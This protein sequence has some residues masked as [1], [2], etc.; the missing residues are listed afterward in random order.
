MTKR[1]AALIISLCLALTA[2][3]A[4]AETAPVVYTIGTSGS[5][6]PFCYTDENG[7]LTGYDV[8]VLRAVDEKLD[9]V[10]FEFKAMDFDGLFLGLDAGSLDFISHQLGKNAEREAKYLYANEPLGFTSMNLAV[11]AADDSINGI[12]DAEGKTV[13]VTATGLPNTW[14]TNYNAETAEVPVTLKYYEGDW[15]QGMQQV[16]A[17]GGD[18]TVAPA[19]NIDT[20]IREMGLGVR[21]IPEALYTVNVYFIF[22]KGQEAL[23]DKID[24]ALVELR[25][26]GTLGEISVTFL[27][28]DYTRLA[29]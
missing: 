28:G 22:A 3:F 1:I 9:D 18:A 5:F 20:A 7:G 21:R 17:G 26:D 4:L 10:S 27:G 25:E 8:E 13:L 6:A 16:V 14:L 15:V 19:V 29:E 11:R 12:K 2:A 24:A 23:R